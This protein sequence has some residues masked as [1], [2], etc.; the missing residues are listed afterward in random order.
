[1][2]IYLGTPRGFCAGVVRAI[3]IVEKVLAN[4]AAF[5]EN[6]APLK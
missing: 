3:E 1:M 5:A 4:V 6:N 2:K